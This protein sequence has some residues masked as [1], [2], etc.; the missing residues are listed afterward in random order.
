MHAKR[1]RDRGIHFE[2]DQSFVAKRRFEIDPHRGR[3]MKEQ[4]GGFGGEEDDLFAARER[5]V[6]QLEKEHIAARALIGLHDQGQ[7]GGN[8]PD[9]LIE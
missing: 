3:L 5:P 7:T 4:G 8:S 6:D 2:Q 1:A 9:R